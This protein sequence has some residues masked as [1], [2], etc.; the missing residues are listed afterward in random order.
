M[1]VSKRTRFEIFR[2]DGFRC[3]YCGTRGNETTGAGLTIDHVIPE[4]LGGTDDPENLVSA[5]GDC[6]AGKTSTAPDS[7]LLAAVDE[8]V[9]AMKAARALALKAMLADMGARDKYDDAAWDLWEQIKPSYVRDAPDG[10]DGIIDGWFKQGVPLAVAEKAFRIAW[11]N[12]G[13]GRR[14]K[15]V[16][17]AGVVRNLMQDA[18]DR[19]RSLAAGDNVI[20][21]DG[22]ARGAFETAS[23]LGKIKAPDGT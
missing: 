23:A 12:S 10:W 14:Q 19:A 16:Y 11:A 3:F 21:R 17:A 20:W 18:E 7:A 1:T 4:A 13:I 15:L 22:Y 2:R 9:A 5:C 8:A 6:N